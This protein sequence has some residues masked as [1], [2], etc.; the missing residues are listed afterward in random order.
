MASLSSFE[1]SDRQPG[2]D[3]PDMPMPTASL[4]CAGAL[5]LGVAVALV[6]TVGTAGAPDG[7]PGQNIPSLAAPG[8][9]ER[10]PE[11][12]SRLREG[13]ELVDQLGTFR[14]TGDR[15]A[16]F[17]EP[18]GGRFVVLENL[19]LERIVHNLEE[20]NYPP[21]WLVTGTLTEYRGENFLL[22][23]RAVVSSRS[24]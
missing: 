2:A 21:K 23:R 15:V 6:Q 17:T 4:C 8:G 19:A 20:Q 18:D 7:P 5:L 3:T 9:A 14:V 22:I 12:A 11:R 24:N 16:F 1:L 13:T 10:T